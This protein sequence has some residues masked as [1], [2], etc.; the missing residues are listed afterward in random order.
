VIAL[1]DGVKQIIT[2]SLQTLNNSFFT[3]EYKPWYQ[4]GANAEMVVVT[5]LTSDVYL[6]LHLKM[7]PYILQVFVLNV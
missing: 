4:C 3:L 1:N 5:T 7:F 6:V 2:S